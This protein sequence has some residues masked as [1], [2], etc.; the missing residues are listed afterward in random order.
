MLNLEFEEDEGRLVCDGHGKK[1][2]VLTVRF[3]GFFGLYPSFSILKNTAF[4]KQD[5]NDRLGLSKVARQGWCL[6]AH[7]RMETVSKIMCS[8]IFRILNNGQSKKKGAVIIL[9]GIH[10]CQNSPRPIP[11][12]PV[13]S[14]F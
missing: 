9:N 2:T 6:L 10:H 1:L 4:W 8:P 5:E 7:L 11:T 3:T 14:L 12:V 13:T